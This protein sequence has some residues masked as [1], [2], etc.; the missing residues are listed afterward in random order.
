[1]AFTDRLSVLQADGNPLSRLRNE[2]GFLAYAEARF[3]GGLVLSSPRILSPFA[4]PLPRSQKGVASAGRQKNG[5]RYSRFSHRRF[6]SS[7]PDTRR[8]GGLLCAQ[9]YPLLADF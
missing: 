4:R 9:R 7:F 2:Q 6:D 3:R 5:N 8:F 1:M